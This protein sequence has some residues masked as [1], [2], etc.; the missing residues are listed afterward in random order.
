[1]HSKGEKVMFVPPTS[2]PRMAE[3]P[4]NRS[5]FIPMVY[6]KIDSVPTQW[7]YHVL[8]I[9]TREQALPDADQLNALGRDGWIM[10]S[11]L[12]QQRSGGFQ[13]LFYFVRQAA[14]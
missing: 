8:T 4:E 6:E 5:T 11:T 9:D 10:V 1:M 3:K 14:G 13:V 7:E 2:H 12:D